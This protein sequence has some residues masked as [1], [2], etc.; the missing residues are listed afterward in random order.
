MSVS[1]RESSATLTER[2]GHDYA[3]TLDRLLPVGSEIVLLDY[4]THRNIGDHLIWLGETTHIGQRTD[5]SVRFISDRFSYSHGALARHVTPKTVILLCGGGNFGDLYPQMQR[6]REAVVEHF[7]DNQFIQLPQTVSFHGPESARSTAD[8]LE[9]H[10]GFTLLARDRKSLE[11]CKQV[12]PCRVELCVDAAFMLGMQSR[13]APADTPIQWISRRDA[14]SA[15]LTAS[16]PEDVDVFD[17]TDVDFSSRAWRMDYRRRR[18][19]ATISGGLV[20]RGLVSGNALGNRFDGTSWTHASAGFTH[21]SRAQ[22]LVTDRLHGH[23]MA[24]LLDIPHV[25]LDNANSK[26]KNF[27]DTWT[28]SASSAHW[29]ES[30]QEAIDIARSLLRPEP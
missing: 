12:L 9:R 27:F 20:S 28:H 16:L 7:P 22:V 1:A 24:L 23:I 30:P 2:L 17:W 13:T 3:A 21:L 29:A 8:T 19:L 25:V 18:L 15:Q 14:E 26:V 11:F 6:M 5:L 4:P 10:G